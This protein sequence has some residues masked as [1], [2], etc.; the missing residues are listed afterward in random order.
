MLIIDEDNWRD[1]IGENGEVIDATGERRK[2]ACFPR[3]VPVGGVKCASL[4]SFPLIPRNEWASRIRDQKQARA[5]LRSLLKDN[6]IP[7]YDQAQ[8]SYCHANSAVLAGVC[9]RLRQ[10]ESP[11]ILSPGSVGGPV[12]GY[13]NEGAYIED[14]LQWMADHGAATIDFVPANQISRSGWKPGA[15]EN[16]KLHRF[17]K[18]IDMG[19]KDSQ[20]FDRCATRLLL[21]DSVAVAYDWWQHSVLLTALVE[22]SAGRFGFEFRNSWSASYGDDGY[23]TLAEG[24]GTPNAAYAPSAATASM[25]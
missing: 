19:Q 20:M 10:G 17:V 22:I 21:G 3:K 25:M 4:P 15:E 11:A 16:A 5:D 6:N 1:Q 2:L 9:C 24:R 7:S 12:T 8:T 18:W 23:A 13:R 14:D